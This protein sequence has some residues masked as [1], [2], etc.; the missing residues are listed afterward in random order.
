MNWRKV[1]LSNNDIANGK[2]VELKAGFRNLYHNHGAPRD[3]GMYQLRATPTEYFFPPGAWAIAWTL[4]E[5]FGATECDAPKESE[6]IPIVTHSV[7][8][9]VPFAAKAG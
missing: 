1:V 5:E 4:L 7:S 9:E 3:A 6:V 8:P 2:D